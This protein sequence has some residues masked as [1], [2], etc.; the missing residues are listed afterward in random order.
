MLDSP[1]WNA[2]PQRLTPRQKMTIEG[3]T[4][5]SPQVI[6]REI[7]EK[8]K[9]IAFMLCLF[10]GPLGIH[11][12]YVRK[13][14]TGVTYMFTLGGLG[15]GWFVDLVNILQGTFQDKAGGQLRAAGAAA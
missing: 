15:V 3:F 12:I 14:G 9:W 13:Y 10:L 2:F 4:Y 8:R 7:S 11:R 1:Q 5:T 6:S